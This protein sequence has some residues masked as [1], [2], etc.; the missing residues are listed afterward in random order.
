MIYLLLYFLANVTLTFFAK[1]AVVK[2]IDGVWEDV[3]A[4]ISQEDKQP[5]IVGTLLVLILVA[6]PLYI[7]LFIY[8][9]YKLLFG[10]GG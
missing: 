3:S 6:V 10:S 8:N 1:N 4:L 2:S 9:L 5:I 7:G